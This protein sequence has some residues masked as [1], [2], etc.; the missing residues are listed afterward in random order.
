MNPCIGVGEARPGGG[1]IVQGG[2]CGQQG[3][4]APQ[5]RAGQKKTGET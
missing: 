5:L 3:D 4:Q 2:G 1:G